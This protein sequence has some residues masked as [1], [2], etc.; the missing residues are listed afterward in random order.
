MISVALGTCIPSAGPLGTEYFEDR[1]RGGDGACKSTLY[2]SRYSN[3]AYACVWVVSL[4]CSGVPM[5]C[6]SSTEQPSR[7]VGPGWTR[8]VGS[9]KPQTSLLWRSCSEQGSHP[10]LQK[11]KQLKDKLN[12][13]SSTTPERYQANVPGASSSQGTPGRMLQVGATWEWQDPEALV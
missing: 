7:C 9:P 10:K 5:I 12:S 6:L 8:S 2:V 11:P 4:S 13:L 3:G 1:L